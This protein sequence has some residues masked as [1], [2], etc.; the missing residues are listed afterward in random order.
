MPGLGLFCGF[1]TTL[2][3]FWEKTSHTMAAIH[4]SFKGCQHY[5]FSTL[6]VS[7]HLNLYR[8]Q[9]WCCQD[10][11]ISQELANNLNQWLDYSFRPYKTPWISWL[12]RRGRRKSKQRQKME[13]KLRPRT[14]SEYKNVLISSWS[15]LMQVDHC[16]PT[17]KTENMSIKH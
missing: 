4:E 17:G 2:L 14:T 13:R 1:Q 6:K 3:H 8:S 12:R 16:M 15:L 11:S 9:L 5:D 10:S 7:E